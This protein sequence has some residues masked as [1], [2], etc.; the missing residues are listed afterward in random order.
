M[1]S[2]AIRVLI[3]DDHM[4]VR[5]GIKSFLHQFADIA[6]IGEAENGVDALERAKKL[7]PDIV[8]MD[9]VMPGMD[10]VEATRRI[11]A[12]MPQ[13]RILALTSFSTDDLV[14][15]ALKAGAAGYLLKDAD[16]KDLVSS[17]RQV[18]CGES[19]LHPSIARKVL[20][21]FYGMGDSK[22]KPETLTERES[23]VLQ[24][25]AR[26]LTNQQI[27]KKLV[28]SQATVRTHVS[29]IL[30][31]LHMAN[32]VQAALYA[33]RSGLVSSDDES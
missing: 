13:V 26:G 1:K 11:K 5:E 31:K 7:A 4:M 17:I 32:R 24:L 22:T 10:G 29:N 6:V 9:L 20:D 15:P 8:L 18:H 19:S 14:F 12:A 25:M 2:G 28:V 30:A 33:L 23:E 27:A 16:P 21:G 3:V